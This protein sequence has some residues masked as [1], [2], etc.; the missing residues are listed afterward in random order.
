[1]TLATESMNESIER[2][3]RELRK[4]RTGKATPSM[5]DS[6]TV[7]YY[8]SM[9]PLSQ[10]ANISVLDARTLSITPWE[11][12]ML[13]PAERAILGANLGVTP[14]NDGDVIRI[15]LPPLTE[16][17]RRDL[18]KQCKAIAE[19]SKVGVRS[20]RRD[21]M[22]SVKQA[23]KDGLPEDA[24]KRYEAS[25]QKMTDDFSGK[26]DKVVDAKEK[27]IMTV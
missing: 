20:A 9:T 15:S 24:G 1:M 7:D 25:I 3:Q 13:Q 21:A 5:L 27:D 4:V 23:V 19:D 14:Q 8:G 6:V 16:E 12:N 2:L 17:R 18:V 22:E 10:I 11:K 26:I